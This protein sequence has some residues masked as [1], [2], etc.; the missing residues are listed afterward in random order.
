M[1]PL[2]AFI[3]FITGT[4]FGSFL[5]VLILRYHS[6]RG[7]SGRSHCASC[8]NALSYEEMIPIFSFFALKGRCKKCGSKISYQ[9]PLVEIISGV[10]FLFVASLSFPIFSTLTI[11]AIFW[12]LLFISVYD[13]YHTI[14][15]NEAV[16][17]VAVL[18]LIFSSGLS[19]NPLIS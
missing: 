3:Y 19:N 7:I 10:I 4:I 14:V 18:S 16:Y 1:D 11:I 9:Y 17:L 12:L 5:N 8:N 6:G 13:I 15:P 2:Y